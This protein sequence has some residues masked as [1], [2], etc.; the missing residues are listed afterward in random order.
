[1]L[2]TLLVAACA[3]AALAQPAAARPY[4]P[5]GV[6]VGYG[7]LNLASET[8]A[9]VMIR[10]LDAAA[11]IACNGRPDIRNLSATA[12]FKRCH[13]AAVSDAVARL[14]APMVSVIFAE[15]FSERP[16]RLASN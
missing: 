14:D 7:D 6:S 5:E 12:Q 4:H 2:T 13:D 10:R 8:G 1:M 3:C 16:L 9:S 15:R 11:T